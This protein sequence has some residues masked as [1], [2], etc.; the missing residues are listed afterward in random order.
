MKAALVST[1]AVAI[2]CSM[3]P[4]AHADNTSS[5]SDSQ[6][7]YQVRKAAAL[8]GVNMSHVFV[9]TRSGEVTLVGW[10]DAS[11]QVAMAERA[12][13]SVNGVTGVDNWLTR[14]R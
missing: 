11:N 1:L 10:V 8:G 2:F 13:T 5:T 6:L 7:A 3:M 4:A 12:A 9:L 14:G